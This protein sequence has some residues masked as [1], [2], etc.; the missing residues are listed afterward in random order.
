M[1]SSDR[2]GG[3]VRAIHLDLGAL[4]A[5]GGT[6]GGISSGAGGGGGGASHVPPHKAAVAG[7]SLCGQSACCPEH[8][9][10]WCVPV[11]LSC[12]HY[13]SA[14]VCRP[15]CAFVH[16]GRMRASCGRAHRLMSCSA[17]CGT[18]F[19]ARNVIALACACSQA[20]I[21]VSAGTVRCV[22]HERPPP[23]RRR[24][25]RGQQPREQQV[26]SSARL[27]RVG[28]GDARTRGWCTRRSH[29]VRHQRHGD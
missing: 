16:G 23:P 12:G 11:C 24:R 1:S 22:Y 17:A 14:F 8:C 15:A 27:P 20:G 13:A 10:D 28:L 6:G 4:S 19:R 25:R 21:P 2:P 3:P 7:C 29:R 5:G 26:C 9:C 18:A